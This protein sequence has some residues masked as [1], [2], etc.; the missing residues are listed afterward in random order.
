MSFLYVYKIKRMVNPLDL[1]PRTCLEL[2]LESSLKVML[3]I[4]FKTCDICHYTGSI[5]HEKT[6]KSS[7]PQIKC[8]MMKLLKKNNYIKGFEKNNN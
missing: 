4:T 7:F 8:R 1:C 3:L 6:K 5:I 2:T